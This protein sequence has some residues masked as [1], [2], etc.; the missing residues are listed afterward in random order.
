[1]RRDHH[2]IAPPVEHECRVGV[3]LDSLGDANA[4]LDARDRHS[5]DA[6]LLGELLL[7]QTDTTAGLTYPVPALWRTGLTLVCWRA[8]HPRCVY[9]PGRWVNGAGALCTFRHCNQRGY[10]MRAAEGDTPNGS[11]EHR[12]DDIAVQPLGRAT[13][14]VTIAVV[15]TADIASRKGPVL[16][17]MAGVAVQGATAQPTLC[18]PCEQERL[19]LTE[20]PGR[21]AL[22]KLR[23]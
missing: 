3:G 17:F 7:R 9:A 10:G 23:L 20:A 18:D 22:C 15:A 2:P 6:D 13:A 14:G 5:V 16:S 12:L 8:G 21:T 4:C 19:E 11:H 1:M